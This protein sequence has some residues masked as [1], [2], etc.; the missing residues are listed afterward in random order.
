MRKDEEEEM[1]VI[2]YLLLF[3][4]RKCIMI[5]LEALRCLGEL[6]FTASW[7]DLSV[8]VGVT[9]DARAPSSQ[10]L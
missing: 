9:D 6:F 7:S 3:G 8:R 5:L 2:C 4:I 10:T 1:F